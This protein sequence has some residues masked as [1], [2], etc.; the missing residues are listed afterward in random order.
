[1]LRCLLALL[2]AAPL[3]A[4]TPDR[5]A[6]VARLGVDTI[7]VESIERAAGTI[8][9][10]VLLR[11]PTTRL[12]R[13]TLILDADGNPT[14]L[15]T[16]E[17]DPVT[18]AALRTEEWTWITDTVRLPNGRSTAAPATA[19][20]FIDLVHWPFDHLLR[21]L[22]A[23][24]SDS[25]DAPML[26]GARVTRFPLAFHGSDSA[27]VTHPTRGTMHVLVRADGGITALDAGATTRALIVAREAPADVAALARRF[28]ARDAASGGMGELSG[29]GETTTT[30]HDAEIELDWGTPR[31]RGRDIWGALVRWGEVWRTGANRATHFTTDHALRFGTLDVPAG[32][33]TLYSIPA[34]DGGVLII[35]TQTGQNGQQ[36]DA[37]RDL[38]RVPLVRRALAAPVEVFTIEVRPADGQ[39][40]ELALKWAGS[41]FVAGFE[42]RP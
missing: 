5:F 41:E 26:S 12:L 27:T 11:S 1:M 32:A 29:R 37:A 20:P 10:D 6:L 7:A 18:A 33:Y 22:R 19:L 38:G 14:R 4:Q 42:V 2:A 13:H 30:V 40:G 16:A 31:M 9:A 39:R 35:N 23:S 21:N 15:V 25:I 34:E 8:T 36:Y 24:E 17:L 3:A 28:A